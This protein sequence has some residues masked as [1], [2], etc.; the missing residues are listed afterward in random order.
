MKS[1]IGV[2]LFSGSAQSNH[3]RDL[4][5]VGNGLNNYGVPLP[6]IHVYS[7]DLSQ[8][9]KNLGL[10]LKAPSDLLKDLQQSTFEIQ[11]IVVTGHGSHDGIVYN[12]ASLPPHT[13]AT[14]KSHD[15][16]NSIKSNAKVKLCI[17]VFGQCFA[18]VFNHAEARSK[19]ARCT[20]C[21]VG[22]TGL[23]SSLN[24]R[25]DGDMQNAFLRY[26]AEWFNKP[27]DVNGDGATTLLDLFHFA[28]TRTNDLIIK[29]RVQW[30]LEVRNL[31]HAMD[32][33][34]LSDMERKSHMDRIQE[35]LEAIH[36]NQDPWLL[37]ANQFRS[38]VL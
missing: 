8:F 18:G 27:V 20:L 32:A 15:F 29:S 22:A 25:I 6:N 12:D 11:I 28:G 14:I 9:G 33:P 1:N 5:N 10:Q 19:S 3:I 30:Y 23:N 16:Y 38:V 4:L 24:T 31:E 34:F 26:I 35:L 36:V 21:P 2:F 13:H 37:N 7:P 17:P